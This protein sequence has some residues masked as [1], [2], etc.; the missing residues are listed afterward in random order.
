MP[1]PVSHQETL[2]LYSTLWTIFIES[3]GSWACYSSWEYIPDCHLKAYLFQFNPPCPNKIAHISLPIHFFE[4]S[5]STHVH[6]S[7]CPQKGTCQP[8]KW[9]SQGALESCYLDDG[10]MLQDSG[11]AKT[12]SLLYMTTQWR[13]FCKSPAEG[14]LLTCDTYHF[15]Q[16]V[17]WDL[18]SHSCHRSP[19]HTTLDNAP[20]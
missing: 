6:A 8:R 10:T 18:G 17:L 13:S 2:L 14:A 9:S 5:W 7:W 1:D 15:N 19:V 4:S 16:H 11:P 3:T 20:S 12:A